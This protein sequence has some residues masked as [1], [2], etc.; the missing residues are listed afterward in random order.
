MRMTPVISE[1]VQSKRFWIFII[2]LIFSIM[3]IYTAIG[4]YDLYLRWQAALEAGF[5]IAMDFEVIRDWI[6]FVIGFPVMIVLF[7]GLYLYVLFQFIRISR[8]IEYY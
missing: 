5:P 2:L 8:P 4:I 3:A 6:F 7:V 1:V